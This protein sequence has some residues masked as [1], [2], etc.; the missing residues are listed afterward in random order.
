MTTAPSEAEAAVICGYL[1]SYGIEATYNNATTQ[2]L[3]PT[4]FLAAGEVATTNLGV[5]GGGRQRILVRPKDA[6]AARK[7]LAEA[8]A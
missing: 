3:S 2:L 1:E 5:A 7:A 8:N 6:E 4:S